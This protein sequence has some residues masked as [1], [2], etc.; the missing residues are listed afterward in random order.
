MLTCMFW[1]KNGKAQWRAEAWWCPRRLLDCMPPYQNL[2]LNSGVWWSLLLDVRCLWR[3]NVTYSRLQ[4]NVLLKIIV[5]AGVLF[6]SHSLSSQFTMCYCNEHKLLSALQVRRP[7]QNTAL[8]ARTEQYITA[9]ISGNALKQGSRTHSV[10]RQCS[11]QP[12]L[13]F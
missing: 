10:L 1:L 12:V 11:L 7:E 9:K 3:H 13:P 2:V 8:N 6:Y 5:T 4:T